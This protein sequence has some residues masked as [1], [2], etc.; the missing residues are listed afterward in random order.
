MLR[1][2]LSRPHVLGLVAVLVAGALIWIKENTELL[3]D[4][5]MALLLSGSVAVG[6]I[7][8]SMLR[9]SRARIPLRL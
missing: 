6:I 7:I 5:I 1:R 4:T 2:G 3:T 9:G 8:L